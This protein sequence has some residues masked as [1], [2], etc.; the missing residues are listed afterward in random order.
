MKKFI[1]KIECRDQNGL[2]HKISQHIS[3]N[4]MN[5]DKN[6]E[7]VDNSLNKARFYM[8]SEISGNMIQDIFVSELK[9]ILPSDAEITLSEGEKKKIVIL[10]TKEHHCLADLLIRNSF[11]EINAEIMSVISN[12]DELKPLVEKFDIPYHFVTHVEKDRES[13]EEEV[14]EIIEKYNPDYVILAKYMRILTPNFVEKFGGKIINIHHSFLPAFIGANP[15]KQAFDRGVKMI[16]AT[17]HFVNNDLDEG[18]IIAQEIINVDHSY[19]AKSMRQA[20]R[21]AE[22]SALAK[23]LKYVFEDKVFVYKNKTIILK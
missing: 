3:K 17:S 1:L 7:F 4:S 6:D 2:L 23:A 18:P 22:K 9:D 20:G 11:D 13:H 21:E 12:Y 10:G 14:I 19:N 16:G 5:I 8:R 15:Y